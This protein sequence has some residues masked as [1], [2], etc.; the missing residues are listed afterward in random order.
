MT[1]DIMSTENNNMIFQNNIQPDQVPGTIP[2]HN[3][4]TYSNYINNILSFYIE[5]LKKQ[6]NKLKEQLNIS[7]G[8][9]NVLQKKIDDSLKT[10]SVCME[11][12]IERIF[13]PCGHA[14]LCDQCFERCQTYNIRSCPV[15]RTEG[16]IYKIYI[17]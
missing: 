10:C 15:C 13:I 4:Q 11:N 8:Q 3:L 2:N 12:K 9:N 14:C 16:Q 17:S 7:K 6:I 5:P 1:G